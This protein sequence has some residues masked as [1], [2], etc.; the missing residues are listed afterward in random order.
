MI[1]IIIF[2]NFALLGVRNKEREGGQAGEEGEGG[3]EKKGRF[4]AKGLCLINQ[5]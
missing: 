1:L 5:I 4:I 2:I 3:R